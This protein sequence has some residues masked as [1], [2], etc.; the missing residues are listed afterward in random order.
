[1]I[2]HILYQIGK[3]LKDIDFT[4]LKLLNDLKEGILATW[5]NG[6]A[7][8]CKSFYPSSILGVASKNKLFYQNKK[9]MLKIFL[10]SSVGRAVDC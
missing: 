9:S 6:Y 3:N 1:M 2:Y 7:E 10:G 8:D 5:R 4:L